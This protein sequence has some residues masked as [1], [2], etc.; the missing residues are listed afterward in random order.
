M[1]Y[2]SLLLSILL[3]LALWGCAGGGAAAPPASAPVDQPTTRPEP[4]PAPEYYARWH[5]VRVRAT[6]YSRSKTVARLKTNDR[7]KQLNESPE[8]WLKVQVERTGDIGWVEKRQLSEKRVVIRKRVTR[9][10]AGEPAKPEE[11]EATE[12]A[13]EDD[14][15]APSL[16]GPAPAQ[17]APP[18][19]P[20]PKAKPEIF[21]PF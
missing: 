11:S 20:K 8:G 7:V 14:K 12:P 17:A 13:P 2:P 10:K 16:L 9:T 5:G 15:A 3:C 19:A 6:P 1:R 21:E 18:P 4:A